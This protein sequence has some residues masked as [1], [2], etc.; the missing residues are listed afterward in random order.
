MRAAHAAASVIEAVW[1]PRA[2]RQLQQNE[3]ALGQ[4]LAS[5]PGPEDQDELRAVASLESGKVARGEPLHERISDSAYIDAFPGV[6]KAS[7][8]G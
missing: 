1:P 7:A 8:C 5:S 2:V 3:I 6:G 4:C